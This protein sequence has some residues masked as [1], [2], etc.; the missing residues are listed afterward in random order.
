MA[1]SLEEITEGRLRSPKTTEDESNLL[2]ENIPKS[3]V[4]KNKWAVE[5]F[6]EWKPSGKV[7]V[8]VLDPGGA[9]KDYCELHKVQPLSTDLESMDACSLNYWLS[10]FVQ[11]VANA[12]GKSIQ[13]GPFTAL[14]AEFE[15]TLLNMWEAKH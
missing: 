1:A 7:E 8:P 9:F 14:S 5:V 4:Y 10:K 12:E 15:G 11:E 3:T 2:K 6:R 13:Q